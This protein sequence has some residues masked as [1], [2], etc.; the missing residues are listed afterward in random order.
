[1][2][3]KRK[4]YNTKGYKSEAQK[5][6]ERLANIAQVLAIIGLIIGLLVVASID[7]EVAGVMHI[8]G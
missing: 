5:R 1:M 6:R 2:N 3:I 8:N 7:A 4:A